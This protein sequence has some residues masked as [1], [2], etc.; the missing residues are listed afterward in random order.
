MEYRG[1]LKYPG[2]KWNIKRSCLDE[3]RALYTAD[4]FFTRAMKQEKQRL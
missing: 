2:S 4:D 1:V 3:F